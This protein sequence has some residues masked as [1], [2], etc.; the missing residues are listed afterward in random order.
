VDLSFGNQVQQ[1]GRGKIKDLARDSGELPM[2]VADEIDKL[3]QLLQSGAIDEEEFAQAK[4]KLLN[5][6]PPLPS[7]QP[8]TDL[9]AQEQ[10][11]RFW[12]ML[13]HLSLLSNFAIPIAGVVAP[14]VIWQLKKDELPRID[15]HGKNAV[16]WLIS[17]FIYAVVCVVLAFFLVGFVLLFVLGALSV[18]FPVIAAIKANN[19]EIWEYPF[20]IKFLR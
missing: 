3:Q 15:E 8:V 6:S 10:Q 9:A 2:S 1:S 13:L 18:I 4:S 20:A 11:A 17:T 19:G 14:I 16:N 12:G 5:S 7:D